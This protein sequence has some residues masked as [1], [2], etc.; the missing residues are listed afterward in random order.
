M[1]TR[2]FINVFTRYVSK[3]LALHTKIVPVIEI[4]QKIAEFMRISNLSDL[5]SGRLVHSF[6]T[7][8]R[9][10]DSSKNLPLD[11]FWES[12]SFDTRVDRLDSSAD[13]A[14]LARRALRL[15]RCKFRK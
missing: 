4:K 9:A 7:S 1:S 6:P 11:Y 3:S 15:I 8:K 12:L 13:S 5:A 14:S 2:F 10:S